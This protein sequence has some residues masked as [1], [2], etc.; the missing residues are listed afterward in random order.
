MRKIAKVRSGLGAALGLCL[1][2]TAAQARPARCFTSDDG[3]YPCDF[4]ATGSDGS[5]EIA[6][7][8][9]PTYQIN[10]DEPG[11]AFGFVNFG[12]RNVALPGRYRI[13]GGVKGC[14]VNDETKTRICAE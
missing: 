8:G 10:I 12:G 11:F 1:L 2:A 5:F 7:P 3:A 13:I 14:W 9:K 4:R 6:A